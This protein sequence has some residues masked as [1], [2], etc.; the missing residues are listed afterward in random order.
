MR[1]PDWEQRLHELIVRAAGKPY[2]WG[3]HDCLLWSAAVAKAVT[4]KDHAR[5]HRGKYRSHASAQRYLAGLGFDSPEAL[6]DSLFDPKPV[7]FAGRGDL[8][9]DRDGIPALCMGAFALS[10]GQEGNIEGL[11][12]VPREQWV[13]AWAVGD[14]HSEWPEAGGGPA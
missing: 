5:G 14:H 11:V 9:L 2:A 1:L 12:Q 3:A 13:R 7:G 6:L 4:G 8:V 10:V